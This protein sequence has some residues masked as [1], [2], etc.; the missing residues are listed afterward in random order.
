KALGELEQFA[1]IQTGQSLAKHRRTTSNLCAAAFRHDASRELDPQLHTHFV[2]ANATY[3]PR[4][5]RWF[6][7]E[8]HDMFKAIR[9][10]GKAYQNE[11][12]WECRR[13]GYQIEHI[14]N[15]KGLVEGFEIRG[16]SAELRQRFSK[17][18]KEVEAGMEAF[19][20]EYGREPTPS[21]VSFI[22]R[23]TRIGKLK[24]ITTPEVVARQRSQLSSSELTQLEDIRK[25]AFNNT[26]PASFGSDRQALASARNHLFERHSVLPGYAVLAEALNQ[27]LGYLTLEGLKRN[28]SSEYS[29]MVQLTT[30]SHN[31]ILSEEFSTRKGLEAEHWSIKFVNSTQNHFDS[32]G[33]VEG[34][35]FDFKSEEQRQVVLDTLANRDQ[36]Y[37]IRGRAGAGKTTSLLE[38][39]IGL[40]AAGRN[41]T[42]L[43]PTASA[44]QV[45]KQDGFQRA[46]TVSDFLCNQAE[47]KPMRNAVLIVDEAGLQ[48][49]KQGVEMLKIAQRS[50]ARVLFVGDTR[51]HSAVE[52]GDFLRV[53]ESH[54]KLHTSELKEIRRQVI[55][56]Y[57]AA[58]RS[59]AS[60][61]T[62]AGMEQLDALGWVHEAK[63]HYIDQ[64]ASAYAACSAEYGRTDD[65]LVVTPTW[66]ENHRLTQAIRNQLKDRRLLKDGTSLTVHDPLE[67]TTQ[68][69][70]KAANFSP[71]MIVQFHADA[72][73]TRRGQSFVVESVK[74]GRLLFQGTSNTVDPTRCAS[75]FSVYQARE[76]EVSSGDRILI[77]RNDRASGLAN[78][79]LLTIR[80]QKDGTVET[81]EGKT[82]P[83]TFRT[84]CHGYVV[85]SHKSQGRT[86]DRVIVAAEQLSAKAAYVA[87]SR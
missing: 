20:A 11:L 24:E 27:K 35:A 59:M 82:L 40:Q 76:I 53:L 69:K 44:V 84:F 68:Q 86:H 16:V 33:L 32:L 18:R 60:G 71:A 25:N 22:T 72:G 65:C 79:E 85:T 56:E 70:A 51:Q 81:Q 49:N 47:H 3:D 87:C 21:E 64:A 2:V 54:S 6:A 38:I 26:A 50:R 57:N 46:T 8:T 75:R 14:H 12:A 19:R 1:A 48:S 34:V 31:P 5:G 37:A 42:Y 73:K 41:I 83:P 29:G 80:I 74:D 63:G 55:A 52:A 7:L 43:A 17:R 66:A 62:K 13:L 30:S 10:A 9:Y 36:V 77:R 4:N 39:R 28:V 45:L 61:R 67:W 23:E 78:G 58:I 15:D